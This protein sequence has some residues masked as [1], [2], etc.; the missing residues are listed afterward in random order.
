VRKNAHVKKEK[1]KER[2]TRRVE[3]EREEKRTRLGTRGGEL[4]AVVATVEADAIRRPMPATMPLPGEI[5]LIHICP[6]NR[7]GEE[8]G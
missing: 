6:K 2:E 8:I 1:S 5:G 3:G 7:K 4:I